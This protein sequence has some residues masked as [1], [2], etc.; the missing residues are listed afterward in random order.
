MVGSYVRR[1]FADHELVLTDVSEG[2]TPLDVGDA[3]AVKVAVAEAQP[4]VV[5]H[6]AAATDVDRCEQEP[7]WAERTNA[8]GTQHVVRACETS[9]IPLVYVSTGAVFPGTRAEPYTEA[10]TPAPPNVYARSKHAGETIV[11]ALP[12]H[13]IVRAGWMF[14]GVGR[15]VKFVGKIARMIQAGQTRLEVVDDLVGSP[16]YA[17]DLLVGIRRLVQRAPYGVYHMANAGSC[18]RYECALAIRDALERP[19]VEICPVSSD[20][21]P[22]PAPRRSEALRSGK[23]PA[24]GLGMRPWRDALRDYILTE[25]AAPVE[26]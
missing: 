5:L 20:R 1:A 15:D 11:A 6:L 21:F 22:L 19:A 13:Y 10:D 9:G 8:V 2:W 4:D 16:T 26:S 24:L 3:T 14:G 17:L 12:R 7:A 23:L 18:T 25:L